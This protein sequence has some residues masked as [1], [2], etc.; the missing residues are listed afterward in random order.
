[1]EKAALAPPGLYLHIPF[2]S[3]ICPYC[4]FSVLTGGPEMRARFVESLLAEIRMWSAERDLFPGI[5]TIYF[6]GGTPSALAPEQIGRILDGARECLSISGNAEIFF[7]ANPE[8]VTPESARA[9]QDLGVRMLS[10]GIQSFDAEALRFLGRRHTPEEARQSVEVARAAG[11]EIVSIDLIYGLPEQSPDAWRRTLAEAVALRPDHISSY[12]L[13]F[14]ENTPFGFRLARGKLA[15][16]P[17]EAQADLF[18]ATHR[19]LADQGY[20]A[21]E[22]SNFARSPKHQ[23]RHNRKY[24]NHTP[25]LGVGPSA[26]SFSGR[27]RWWNERKIKPYQARIGAGG[28]PVAGSEELTAGDLAVEALMLGFRT[29]GGIDLARFR[30]RYGVDLAER[31]I[32]LIERL[33][34]EGLLRVEGSRLLPT[35]EGWA[36]ADSLARDFEIG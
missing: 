18:V 5:D 7:E 36:V 8:D 30:D 25:Y 2:C 23:S 14:H 15:E 16:L 33:E 3:A 6:G 31:N 19:F 4:D 13:T 21:Y 22:V 20:P 11:F 34:R 32:R 10:L 12:Q 17:D 24:W 9:W 26:H 35:L 29:A 1:M 28:R 27:R